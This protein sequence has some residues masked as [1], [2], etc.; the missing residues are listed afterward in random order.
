MEVFSRKSYLYFKCKRF[1]DITRDIFVHDE[2]RN[3][4]DFFMIFVS[5]NG[6]LYQYFQLLVN[7]N[8]TYKLRNI[9]SVNS[10]LIVF[11][12]KSV[13]NWLIKHIGKFINIFLFFSTMTSAITLAEQHSMLPSLRESVF[14]WL[15]CVVT[16]EQSERSFIWVYTVLD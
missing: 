5:V 10:H 16:T 9:G 7:Q 11:A 1:L 14:T 12:F 2:V 13:F 8:T 6:I 4:I 3:F 15:S